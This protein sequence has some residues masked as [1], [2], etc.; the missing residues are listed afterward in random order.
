ME[1]RH[2][3]YDG[4]TQHRGQALD[5]GKT[6][7]SPAT[8]LVAQPPGRHASSSGKLILRHEEKV[9]TG[10]CLDLD[11]AK[12]TFPHV[13]DAVALVRWDPDG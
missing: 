9:A 5:R 6:C 7:P 3:T 1:N 4:V 10:G 13:L 2:R 11:Q 12:L 8:T